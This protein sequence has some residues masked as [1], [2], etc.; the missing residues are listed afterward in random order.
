M[1]TVYLGDSPYNAQPV[2]LP[3]DQREAVSNIP[4]N[5]WKQDTGD[6]ETDRETDRNLRNQGYMKGPNAMMPSGTK[7]GDDGTYAT[8]RTTEA[9]PALRRILTT[10]RME[11]DKTYYL[12]FK[13][14]ID[15]TTAQ[16]VLDY[17]E[18]VPTSVVNGAEPE[19][20]W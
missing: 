9:S 1:V 4:G 19:D 5:P 3:I 16:F 17:I 7:A 8:C 10:T 14:A 11:S 12:R 20:I 15:L 2:G 18:L 6:E 13:S